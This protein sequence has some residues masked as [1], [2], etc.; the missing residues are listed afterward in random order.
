VPVLV[1]DVA[2]KVNGDGIVTVPVKVGEALITNVLPVPVC[3]AILVVFPTEVIGPDRFALV[4]TVAAFPP[5]F[6]AVA[7]PVKFVA[8]PEAG[9]P[10]PP[11][12]TKTDPA[13]PVLTPSAVATPVPSPVIDPTAGVI[14]VLD[15]AVINP[16]PLTVRVGDWV[17]VPK[18][19]TLLFTVANVPAAV[20]FPDPLK[21]GEV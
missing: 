11:P 9:V 16:L 21:V 13:V 19:P 2:P 18:D 5:I 1:T 8:T 4:V 17:A 3:E 7:V 14:V 15:T 12:F 10:N 20:T 6:K